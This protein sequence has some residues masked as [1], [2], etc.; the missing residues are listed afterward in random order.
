M[1]KLSKSWDDNDGG[2]N[3][4]NTLFERYVDWQPDSDSS[5]MEIDDVISITDQEQDFGGGALD[6]P[7]A[8]S[9]GAPLSAATPPVYDAVEPVFL[10][11]NAPT[12]GLSPTLACS[13]AP[14]SDSDSSESVDSYSNISSNVFCT[15]CGHVPKR[16][17]DLPRHMTI[18]Q[19]PKHRCPYCNKRFSRR[20]SLRRHQ[21]PSCRHSPIYGT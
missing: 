10:S 8:L 18:H 19:K 13:S 7:D 14:S 3:E 2:D 4:Y 16:A 17:R 5:V 20:H 15:I 12:P 1:T 11:D 9:E 6:A 21:K